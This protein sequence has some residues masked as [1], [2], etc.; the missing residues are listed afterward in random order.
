MKIWTLKFEDLSECFIVKAVDFRN[1][2]RRKDL[3]FRS[4]KENGLH[5]LCVRGCQEN[6]RIVMLESKGTMWT[7]TGSV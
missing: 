6:L 1:L 7:V 2:S 3:R 4:M 5:Y